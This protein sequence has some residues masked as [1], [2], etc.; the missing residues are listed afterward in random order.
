MRRALATCVVVATMGIGGTAGGIVTA[1]VAAPAAG[2]VH[3]QAA[4]C[5]YG[6]IG[7]RRKCLRAGEYCA[8][9]YQRQY[10]HYGFTCNKLDYRGDWH[11]ERL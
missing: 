8:R 4:S 9:R 3:A 11:L 1:A 5:V 6:R 10:I 7:G 2:A